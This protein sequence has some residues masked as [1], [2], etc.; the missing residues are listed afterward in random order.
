MIYSTAFHRAAENVSLAVSHL[1]SLLP[2][3]A[4]PVDGPLADAIH[5]LGPESREMQAWFALRAIEP[6][7]AE[8]REMRARVEPTARK[9]VRTM[10]RTL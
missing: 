3:N 8:W 9:I 2:P 1:R 6:F 5:V 4:P 10:D 7:V